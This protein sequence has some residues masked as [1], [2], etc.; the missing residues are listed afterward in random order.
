MDFIAEVSPDSL[1][2]HNDIGQF[3]RGNISASIAA[4][5]YEIQLNLIAKQA[6]G[7][8]RGG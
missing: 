8:P 2:E 7:L 1:H 4:G 3:Y 5:T 6:L